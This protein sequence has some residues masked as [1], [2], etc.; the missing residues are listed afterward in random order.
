MGDKKFQHFVHGTH[1]EDQPELRHCHGDETPQE[2]GRAHR[3][4]EWQGA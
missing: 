1:E 2:D 4:A 3:T